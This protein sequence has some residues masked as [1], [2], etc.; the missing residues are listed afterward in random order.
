VDHTRP[1]EIELD[2][3]ELEEQLGPFVIGHLFVKRSTE[4]AHRALKATLAGC[5]L[6]R[7][8]D[9]IDGPHDASRR[10]QHNMRRNPC[11]WCI[12]S[13][14]D[15]G[16]TRV[17][18]LALVRRDALVNRVSNHGVDERERWALMKQIDPR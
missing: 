14:Q 15:L 3:G 5:P 6:G 1:A 12:A 2:S 9:D 7:V 17:L 11:G 18:R 10:C 13:P 8:E 16:C 4:I